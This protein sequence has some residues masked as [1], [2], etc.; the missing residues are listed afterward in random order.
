MS[1]ANAQTFFGLDLKAEG[2]ANLQQFLEQS[3]LDLGKI[4]ELLKTEKK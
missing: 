1:G 2:G 3:G 4:K